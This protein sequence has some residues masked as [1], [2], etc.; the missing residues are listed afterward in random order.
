LKEVD[1]IAAEDTRHS[2]KLL[3]HFEIKTSM[4]SY[5]EH[6]KVKKAEY[7]V[8]RMLDGEDV[9]LV[10]DAGTPGISDPGEE[11][12]RRAHEAGILVVSLPGASACIT[13]LAASGLPTGS[14][15]FEAFLPLDKKKRERVMDRLRMET[16]TIVLYEAP[17]RLLR[18]L[19]ELY[20][21]L[22]ERWVAVCKELTKKYESIER[23]LL[24]RVVARYEEVEPKG[25]FVL[26]IQGISENEVRDKYRERWKD[27]SIEE[28]MEVYLDE[29]MEKKEAM[30]RVAEDRGITK[31]EV[32]K[33]LL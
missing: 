32:Y 23:D 3:N 6:N 14:F 13:A 33:A 27:V 16:R 12:V 9:A 11:L 19:K 8:Q 10:T 20:G 22:G 24:S 1:V 18:T 17:H 28:Q 31:R 29:G 4:T 21:E 26:V 2:V 5:H 30:K 25:E 7:L 15:V